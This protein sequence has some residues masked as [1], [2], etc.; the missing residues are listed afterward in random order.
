MPAHTEQLA[1]KGQWHSHPLNFHAAQ[2]SGEGLLPFNADKRTAVML[3]VFY[4]L[5]NSTNLY[6]LNMTDL[7]MPTTVV[8]GSRCTSTHA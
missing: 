7:A 5:D 3:A 6:A 2:L 8:P 1:V 4:A